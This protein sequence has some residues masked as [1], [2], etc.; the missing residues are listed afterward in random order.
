MKSESIIRIS[1]DASAKAGELAMLSLS[2]SLSLSLPAQRPRMPA[3]PLS[4]LICG[5]MM[6]PSCVGS[7]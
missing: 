2:L 6:N 3:H 5:S 7:R 4:R 1:Y